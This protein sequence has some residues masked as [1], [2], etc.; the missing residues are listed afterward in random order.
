MEDSFKISKLCSLA[1][2]ANLAN[3]ASKKCPNP[4]KCW[5]SPD[6]PTFA[7]QFGKDSPDSPTF[8]KQFRRTRQTRHIRQTLFFE[9]NVTRLDTFARVIHQFGEFGVSGH[10]LVLTIKAKHIKVETLLLQENITAKTLLTQE[11]IKA[12]SYIKGNKAKNIVR[13]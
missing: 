1:N 11:N 4:R 3:L 8:A 13:Y 7:N 5:D 10:C 6:S 9:K 2:L 12:D